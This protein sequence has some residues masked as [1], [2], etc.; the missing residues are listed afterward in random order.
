MFFNAWTR[1]IQNSDRCLLYLAKTQNLRMLAF[2]T[3]SGDVHEMAAFSESTIREHT[4]SVMC[5]ACQLC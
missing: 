3:D 1:N 5:L 4:E 2:C